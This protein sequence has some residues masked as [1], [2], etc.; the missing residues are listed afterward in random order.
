MKL[1]FLGV[2]GA[3]AL[4]HYQSNMILEVDG[5]KLLFENNNSLFHQLR[6]ATPSFQLLRDQVAMSMTHDEIHDDVH[7]FISKLLSMTSED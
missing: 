3:F 6:N 7:H 1:T 4:S 2:G 5:K